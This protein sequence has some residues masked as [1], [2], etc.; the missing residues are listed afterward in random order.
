[1][2]AWDVPSSSRFCVEGRMTAEICEKSTPISEGGGSFGESIGIE[3]GSF[4]LVGF[5]SPTTTSEA[6][7]PPPPCARRQDALL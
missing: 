3:L 2:K 5:P 7:G 1:M 6:D 4:Q